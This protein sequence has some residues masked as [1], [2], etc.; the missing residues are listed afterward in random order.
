MPHQCAACGQA[1]ADGS[2][3]MLSGCP[4]CGGNKF[5][6]IPHSQVTTTGADTAHTT[7]E[8]SSAADTETVASGD[9][10]APGSSNADSPDRSEE[11]TETPPNSRSAAETQSASDK[12]RTNSARK[13]ASNPDES[14]DTISRQSQED[15]AQASARSEVIDSNELPSRSAGTGRDLA[16]FAEQDTSAPEDEPDLADLRTELNTQFESIKIVNPGE[17]ELNLMELYDRQ[18]Y[19][20]SLQENGRYVIEMPGGWG[21]DD[22]E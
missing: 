8:R 19:I 18:E 15:S 21:V 20:I 12:G 16:D 13:S 10:A 11:S 9:T 22:D 5:Q 4:E 14:A 2:K 17:Y 3:E 1:F 6:F 7:G